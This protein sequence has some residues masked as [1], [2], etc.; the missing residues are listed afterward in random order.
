M[1]TSWM[2]KDG[3][4]ILVVILTTILLYISLIIYTRLIGLRSYSKLSGFDFAI[5]V[6]FGSVLGGA[7]LS[8]DPPLVQAVVALGMLYLIQ[9]TVSIFRRRYKSFSNLIDNEP[10]LIMAGK[11]IIH[12]NLKKGK[13]T[14]A[15][16]RAKLREANVIKYDEIFAV[17]METTGDVSV[18]HGN[19]EKNK[20]DLNLFE[21]VCGAERLKA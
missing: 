12:E 18:L 10:L 21:G 8:K 9:L 5:T 7:I 4:S 19:P 17:V 2:F 1:G 16:L 3:S 20:L 11:E 13:L 15:D 14:E 6:A